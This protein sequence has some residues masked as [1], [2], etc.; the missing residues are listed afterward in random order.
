MNRLVL[1]TLTKNVAARRIATSCPHRLTNTTTTTVRFAQTDL[2]TTQRG[3]L[4]RLVVG[5]FLQDKDN[6]GE[7]YLGIHIVDDDQPEAEE[8]IYAMRRAVDAYFIAENTPEKLSAKLKPL[9]SRMINTVRFINSA[10]WSK[11]TTPNGYEM[12][13]E[14]QCTKSEMEK[15]QTELEANDRS[16]LEPL[17]NEM[18]YVWDLAMRTN[19]H[20]NILRDLVNKYQNTFAFPQGDFGTLCNI[21]DDYLLVTESNMDYRLKQK[22][23]TLIE[24][25]LVFL[26]QKILLPELMV[27]YPTIFR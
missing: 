11:L 1:S 2:K 10:D 22:F 18:N 3:T 15:K 12:F 19:N 21:V 6:H 9:Y 13:D 16:I 24:Q 7:D 5:K 20:C 27:K 17:Y 4:K 14:W 8:P 23:S 26:K 25:R